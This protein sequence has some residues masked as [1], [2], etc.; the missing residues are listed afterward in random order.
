MVV[1]ID[2][3]MEEEHELHLRVLLQ[4]LR[5]HQ[6][7]DKFFKCAF[8]FTEVKFLGHVIFEI[9]VTVDPEKIEEIGRAHV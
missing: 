2:L 9:G 3:S 5:E 6:L 7:Y 8:W 1:F 4:L